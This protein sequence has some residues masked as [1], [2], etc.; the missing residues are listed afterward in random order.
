MIASYIIA[1]LF[2]FCVLG[3]DK[4]MSGV[5][6]KTSA[7]HVW[8]I[9]GAA[10]PALLQEGEGG[11][12]TSTTLNLPPILAVQLELIAFSSLS[13]PYVRIKLTLFATKLPCTTSWL[14]QLS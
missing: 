8:R 5:Y 13:D 7:A 3:S 1:P 6:S 4:Y 2:T 11:G 10:V 9:V 12:H 14:L